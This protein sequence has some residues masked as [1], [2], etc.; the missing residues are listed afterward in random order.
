MMIFL[1]DFYPFFIQN[2]TL[3]SYWTH[4]LWFDLICIMCLK[5]YQSDVELFCVATCSFTSGLS[6]VLKSMLMSVTVSPSPSS[7]STSSA[8]SNRSPSRNSPKSRWRGAWKCHKIFQQIKLSRWDVSMSKQ[9]QTAWHCLWVQTGLTALK[10]DTIEEWL[11]V[12]S[13]KGSHCLACLVVLWIYQEN[14][15]FTHV[16]NWATL[17]FRLR[18]NQSG[19]MCEVQ[20]TSKEDEL[21]SDFRWEH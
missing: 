7:S 11:T 6:C 1:Q 3:T 2:N 15:T 13:P 9:I 16:W 12:E 10:L 21:E 5:S 17:P 4:T 8:S 18:L 19:C 14:L 20:P